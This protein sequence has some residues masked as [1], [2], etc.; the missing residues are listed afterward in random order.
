L[1]IATHGRGIW[2]VDDISP[3]RALRSDVVASEATL[4]PG[5]PAQQR[6]QSNGGWANGDA[7]Y[8]GQ[9]PADGVVITYYQKARQVIGRITIEVMDGKGRLQ[10]TIPASNRKGLNRV[11]WSMRDDPPQTPRGAT[12]VFQA[13][14]GPRVPPGTYM[15]HLT[16]GKN[17]YTMPLT[18]GLDRRATFTVADKEAQ[19]AA[20]KHVS[21]LF[22]RMSVLNDKIVDV[23]T[24]A[25]QRAAAL[26]AGD[27]LRA[28]L[29]GLANDATEL[30]KK[31][32]ATTEGGAITGEER[33]REHMAYV[34]GAI[35]SVEDRPTPYQMARVDALERELTD[36]EGAFATLSTTQL[37]D[38]N[39]A[40][41][42]KTQPE[43]TVHAPA[44]EKSQGGGGPANQLAKRLVGLR[45]FGESVAV[46]EEHGERD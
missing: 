28:K 11:V 44:S 42:A 29:A 2:I 22:G 39:R 14:Q 12:L 31:I 36:V 40:L 17:T 20:A 23:S 33:L 34:Y 27:A 13:A 18:V 45:I 41:K 3:L 21:A 1:V 7:S 43:I 32:V 4:I 38:V 19:Y 10:T 9:N 24:Q 37:A 26:P 6:I 16:K 5:R 30:R 8:S 25:Q 35:L 15:V 46:N